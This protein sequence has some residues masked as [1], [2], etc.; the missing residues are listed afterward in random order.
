MCCCVVCL[1]DARCL[2]VACLIYVV[3]VAVGRRCSLFALGCVWLVLCCLLFRVC[4]LL[5]DVCCSLGVVRCV[6]CV[7]FW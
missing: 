7:V 3:N 5:F 4:C 2:S 1:F 6:L